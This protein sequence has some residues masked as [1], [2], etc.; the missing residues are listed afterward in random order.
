M[1]ETEPR[2]S[3]AAILAGALYLIAGLVFAALA[4][5][6]PS[7]ALRTTWRSAAYLVSAFVF[8]VHI[9]HEHMRGSWPLTTAMHASIGVALGACAL[10]FGSTLHGLSTPSANRGRRGI[11]LLGV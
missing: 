11:A 4:G 3:R 8:A 2:W 5:R 6:A 1:N 10:A 9:L 7:P